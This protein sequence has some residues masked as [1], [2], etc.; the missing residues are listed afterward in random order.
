MPDIHHTLGPSS[1]ARW[2]ECPGSVIGKK[3]PSSRSTDA[4]DEGT[5]CHKLLEIC[6]TTGVDPDLLIGSVV[7]VPKWPV[8]KEMAGAVRFFL[9]SMH[10]LCAELG[11]EAT[12]DTLVAEQ[13]LVD[14]DLPGAD[15][16]GL[17][18]FGG[19]TDVIIRSKGIQVIG[20]LKYG[21]QPVHASSQQL[22]CYQC[23]ALKTAKQPITRCVQFIVQPRAYNDEHFTRHEPSIEE[24]QGLYRRIQS[25][26]EDLNAH[27]NL[28]V[29]PEHMLKTGKH[30][31]YCPKQTDCPLQLKDLTDLLAASELG[32]L[33]YEEASLERLV[34]WLEK[35]EQLESFFK[36]VYER[37]LGYA[38]AGV[39][40]PGKK[41]VAKMTNR[42]L[43][44]TEDMESFL[45]NLEDLCG[46]P[47]G[48][49]WE[50]KLKGIGALEK[51][52]KERHRDKAIQREKI[53]TFNSRFTDRKVVGVSLVD[54]GAKGDEVLQPEMVQQIF[55]A[56]DMFGPHV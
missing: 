3:R 56:L 29:A 33:S 13:Y 42:F 14:R 22:T 39:R 5:A 51:M 40:I 45:R 2:L 36:K 9:D 52:I 54:S 47:G 12:P 37:L 34:Y 31:K 16:N 41:L 53:E 28:P 30:C 35:Q 4:A 32:D 46:V 25:I 55:E 18:W 38:Q 21:A 44:G 49:A 1:S 10:G 26:V 23:L 19:T 11:I 24:V 27:V 20:D 8:T 17:P 6:L 48:E 43:V 7:T 50:P 15:P